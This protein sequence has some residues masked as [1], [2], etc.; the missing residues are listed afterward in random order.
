MVRVLLA[1]I[2]LTGC[3][4]VATRS[5]RGAPDRQFLLAPEGRIRSI[6][7]V[8]SS[9][10]AASGEAGE[11]T[12]FDLSAGGSECPA[13]AVSPAAEPRVTSRAW[14]AE[15]RAEGFWWGGIRRWRGDEAL[16]DLAGHVGCVTA[17][18]YGPPGFLLS[19][20]AAG[21][22]RCWALE[23]DRLHREYPTERRA[24]RAAGWIDTLPAAIDERGI[25]YVWTT[26]GAVRDRRDLGVGAVRQACFATCWAALDEAGRTWIATYREDD[27]QVHLLEVSPR[28]AIVGVRL[29]DGRLLARTGD[30]RVRS[31]SWPEGEIVGFDAQ[32]VP[33]WSEP[34]PFTKDV[35]GA[36][37]EWARS[38]DG[39]H[40]A[41]ATAE[42]WVAVWE[43]ATGR[44]IAL[45]KESTRCLAF[46][47]TEP[48]LI[49]GQEDGWVVVERLADGEP[50]RRWRAHS[51]AVRDVA[52]DGERLVTAGGGD[53]PLVVWSN[54]R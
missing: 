51:S 39:I 38:A 41:V 13:P 31:Y 9:I 50:I 40:A 12:F 34:E 30:D 43:I 11:Q 24:I 18:S 14:G 29:E 52:T 44:R 54:W 45:R 37:I 42:G 3:T 22:V 23:E 48:W 33:P 15:E 10:V 20:D 2:L 49:R 19:G 27:L 28:A 6:E 4:L 47:P 1:A 21:V 16:P 17:L 53:E 46:H 32:D 5:D 7:L 36:P 26:D 35:P 8:R 25:L